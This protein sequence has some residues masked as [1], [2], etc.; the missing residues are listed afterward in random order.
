MGIKNLHKFLQK[1]HP[2]Y[3]RVSTIS[4]YTGKK[5][6]VD[7]NVYLY[8]MKKTY[9][10]RWAPYFIEF[11]A[12]M[13]HYNID[14]IYVYDTSSPLEKDER[15]EE[16]R[17]RRRYAVQRISDIQDAEA[18][19]RD[20][21]DIAPILIQVMD[22]RRK[23]STR[24]L[25]CSSGLVYDQESIDKE[26]SSL[27]SQALTLTRADTALSKTILDAYNVSYCDS[28]SEAETLCAHLCC[29]GIVDAVL[30]EDTDVMVYGTPLFITKLELSRTNKWSC[31]EIRIHDVIEQLQ[32]SKEQFV[33]FC[34]MCG[35]DYNRNIFRMGSEKSYKL[36][37]KHRKLETVESDTTI[38][39]T[40]L[41]FRRVRSLFEVPGVLQQRYTI[42]HGKQLPYNS[43][44]EFCTIYNLRPTQ[45]TLTYCKT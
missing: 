18:A 30:S 10:D 43:L 26:L 16:R 3:G 31:M 42:K 14:C 22:K 12:T 1:H 35:T 45:P 6:A 8:Q 13:V 29:H 33:D 25:P 2:E 37:T 7:T 36:I 44:M 4:A 41:N 38:D 21:G 34:I 11:V 23:D 40:I 39:T 20:S 19:Y 15:K 24:L 9:K 17:T 32:L 27:R 5:I 28:V